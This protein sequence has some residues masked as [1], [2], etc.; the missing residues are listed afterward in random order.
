MF[1]DRLMDKEVVAHM[2]AVRYGSAVKRNESES[3]VGRWMNLDPVI[4]SKVSQTEKIK[5]CILTHL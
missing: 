5:Y 4:Q 3:P 1:I 2:H